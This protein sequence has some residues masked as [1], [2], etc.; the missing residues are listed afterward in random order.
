MA[1][2]AHILPVNS[3]HPAKMPDIIE[4]TRRRTRFTSPLQGAAQQ[5]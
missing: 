5:C 2:A 4:S 3:I 1:R